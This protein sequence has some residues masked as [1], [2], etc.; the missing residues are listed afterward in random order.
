MQDSLKR[1]RVA[2][3]D[4]IME[5]S[6]ANT[7]LT[8]MIATSHAGFVFGDAEFIDAITNGGEVDMDIYTKGDLE[9]SDDLN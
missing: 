9:T 1:L 6:T 5:F 4:V 3:M 8:A 7:P 2:I